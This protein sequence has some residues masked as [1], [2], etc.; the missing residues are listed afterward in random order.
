MALRHVTSAGPQLK[1]CR[2]GVLRPDLCS[3]R[4]CYTLAAQSTARAHIVTL[5][6][7]VNSTVARAVLVLTDFFPA[8]LTLLA[9]LCPI[10]SA[11]CFEGVLAARTTRAMHL[12][13]WAAVLSSLGH[14][15]LGLLICSYELMARCTRKARR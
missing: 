5:D 1:S 11:A 3:S 8:C 13:E 6:M 14:I 2:A 7:T 9:Q 15:C 4:A 12:T 10:L